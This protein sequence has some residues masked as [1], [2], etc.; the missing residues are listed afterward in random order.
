LRRIKHASDSAAG[1]RRGAHTTLQKGLSRMRLLYSHY[2]AMTQIVVASG[3]RDD[4]ISSNIRNDSNKES[5]NLA[6]ES[7]GA[8]DRE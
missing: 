2:L 5:G 8:L 4:T 3:G 1:T 7:Q 6:V